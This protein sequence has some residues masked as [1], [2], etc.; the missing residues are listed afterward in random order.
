MS[1]RPAVLLLACLVAG[2]AGPTPFLI[3]GDAKSAEVGYAG[4]PAT[5]WPIARAH[6]ARYERVPRLLQAQAN[7]AYYQCY[8]P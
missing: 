3:E 2:C 7:T 4:D 6:C 1:S 8:R 5:A